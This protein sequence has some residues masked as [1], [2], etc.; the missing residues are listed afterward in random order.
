MKYICVTHVDSITKVPGFSKP[1]RNGPALPDVKGL[2]IE[3]WDQ[4]NWPLTH[5][6][7][8]P[9]FFG[10]CDDDADLTVDG[11]MMVFADTDDKT[12]EEQYNEM[13]A[14]EERARLPSVASPRQV[15]LALLELNLLAQVQTFVEALPEP[16]KTAVVIEW[17]YATEI[18]KNSQLITSLSAQMGLTQEQV[19]EIF[20]LAVTK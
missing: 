19:D 15:R 13:K 4:S 9:R 14:Q 18:N 7:E 2:T 1:M 11:V 12:A 16:D 20:T 17:E 6:D 3:W 8:F 10:S 5:P